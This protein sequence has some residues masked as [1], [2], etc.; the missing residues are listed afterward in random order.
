MKPILK[1]VGH[2]CL[3]VCAGLLFACSAPSHQPDGVTIPSY[4]R[5]PFVRLD[6]LVEHYWDKTDLKDSV[7]LQDTLALKTRFND[8]IYLLSSYPHIKSKMLIKQL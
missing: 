4:P 7:W 1:S 3:R 6:Y 5:N 2:T 8:Y